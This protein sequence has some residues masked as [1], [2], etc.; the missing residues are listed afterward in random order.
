MTVPFNAI[1]KLL[2]KFFSHLV[3]DCILDF[4]ILGFR[5]L[6]SQGTDQQPESSHSSNY[7]RI[8]TG[9]I[10]QNLGGGNEYDI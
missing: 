4:Y 9:Q 7:F 10:L 3:I 8:C 6:S 1:F 2:L 5:L